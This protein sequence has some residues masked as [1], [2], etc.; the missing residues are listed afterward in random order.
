MLSPPASVRQRFGRGRDAQGNFGRFFRLF[1]HVVLKEGLNRL[2]ESR[3]S[4][5]VGREFI[6]ATPTKKL[7][8]YPPNP[9]PR[10]HDFAS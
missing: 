7:R 2:A 3:A 1:A 4:V 10:V 6:T 5:F 8:P 9:C